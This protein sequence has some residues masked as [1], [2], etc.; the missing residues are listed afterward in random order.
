MSAP[1]TTSAV[2]ARLN[3]NRL[4][5]G[6]LVAFALCAATPLT[7]VAGVTTTGMALTGQIG[8]PIAFVAIAAVLALFAVGYTAM[9]ARIPNAGAFY[10]FIA[11]GINP[12]LGV[13]AAWTAYLAYTALTAGLYGLIGVAAPP[14]LESWFGLTVPW[15]VAA[16]A[17]WLLVA[18]LGTRAVDLNGRILFGL[19][20]AEAALIV[21]ATIAG[22]ANPAGGQIS[23]EA[24]D[25]V[26]FATAGGAGA[27]LALGFL[28][29]IGFEAPAVYAEE[30]RDAA[31]TVRRA[32]FWSL[33]ALVALYA[34]A[35]WAIT[36]AVGPG[37]VV[38]AAGTHGIDLYFGLIADHLGAPVANAASV[39]LVTSLIAAAISFHNTTSRYMFALG[40][41]RVLPASLGRTMPRTGAPARA[42]LVQSTV[43]A[44]IIIGYAAAGLDPLVDMFYTLG[45]A[46]GYAVLWLVC[47]A[48]FAVLRY[49]TGERSFALSAAGQF[50]A[51]LAAVSLS[52]IVVLATIDLGDLLGVEPASPLPVVIGAIMAAVALAGV[53]RGTYMAWRR[54]IVYER[55]GA[56]PAADRANVPAGR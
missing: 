42:S 47:V 49:F 26:T 9:A 21:A 41:E 11:R 1:P 38:N 53:L 33:A 40:R 23:L 51:V 19:L 8:L 28:G 31:H 55:I 56:G 29:S 43:S 54:P 14:L 39:L 22:F 45:T 48:A 16:G 37:N 20:L 32:V 18:V 44:A 17:C 12:A 34:P 4:G 13:G 2:T 27:L 24:L 6:P 52:V 35:A 3:A 50:A 5:T 10:A 7:V 30:A 25:P 46:G 36:V 15:W